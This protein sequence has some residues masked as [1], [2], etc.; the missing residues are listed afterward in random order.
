MKSS[1]FISV[2]VA[3]FLLGLVGCGGSATPP[4]SHGGPVKDSVSLIDHLRAANVTVVPPGTMKHPFFSVTCQV[5][6]V[7]SEQVQVYEYAIEDVSSFLQ[8]LQ[9][10]GIL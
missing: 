1:R 2:F 10:L 8:F 5:M 9:V 7:N 4:T 3:C 6:M